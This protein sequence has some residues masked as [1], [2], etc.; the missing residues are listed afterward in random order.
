MLW[1]TPFLNPETFG[2]GSSAS[3]SA[4]ASA[5]VKKGKGK[6]RVIESEDEDE[7]EAGPRGAWSESEL[8]AFVMSHSLPLLSEMGPSNFEVWLFVPFR[9]TLSSA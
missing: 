2:A 9:F 5:A 6:A 3:A 1:L 4:S 7:E 8:S